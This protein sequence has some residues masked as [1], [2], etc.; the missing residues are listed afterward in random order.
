[1]TVRRRLALTILLTGLLTAAGVVATVALAFQ[2]FE[3]ES[4]Y[5]RA[6]AFLGR[7]VGMYPDLLD[8]QQ[9]LST[10]QPE[11][12]TQ[13]LRNLLLFEP[14]SQLYLLAAD[15]TVLAHTGQAQLGAGFK[16]ALAPVQQAAA[17][18]RSEAARRAAP[19][20]MGDDPEHMNADAVVAARVLQRVRIGAGTGVDGYLYLV[21]RK[22]ALPGGKTEAFRSSLAGPALGGVV[23]LIVLGAL[24]TAWII[25]T[26]TQPLRQLSDEVAAASR[27]GFST[28]AAAGSAPGAVTAQDEFGRLRQGFRAM[29]ATLRQQWDELKRLDHFRRESVS[30][31]SHDLRSPLT[32]T[33]A[34]LETLQTRWAAA[35]AQAPAAEDQ[36]LVAVA[37]RNTRKAAGL[38][39]SLGDLALLDEPEFRLRP[40]RLDLAEV[41][42]DICRRF[43][44][45]AD[46]QGVVLQFQQTGEAAA[47]AAVDVELFERAVANLLDN[48]FKYTPAGGRIG[49]GVQRSGDEVWVSVQDNGAGIAAEALPQLFDRLVQ[50][51]SSGPPAGRDEGKGLGL[52]IVK[53]I[54]ELHAGAVQVDSTP[55]QGTRV[56]LR[57][58]AG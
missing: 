28:A 45:R 7:V 47:V 55:G 8:Q 34:C 37:L 3:H 16:V 51:R 43:A 21:C 42:D 26:I 9:R 4:T 25:T 39:R 2:R 6:E 29:L 10:H 15:G 56:T 14:D 12:F 30:N 46:R 31:L 20:V 36:Q 44:P 48:A 18:A 52:A 22:Q 54:A 1:M 57:F 5:A 17:A 58:P 35:P 33:V 41:L 49:L 24:G 19:Y 53:R 50:A 11:A 38:V 27:D 32:A 40:M 23:V 13:F